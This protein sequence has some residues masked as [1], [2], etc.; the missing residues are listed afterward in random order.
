ME[1]HHRVEKGYVHNQARALTNRDRRR[2]M[3]GD[4][5]A[6]QADVEKVGDRQG[7]FPEGPVASHVVVAP[8]APNSTRLQA[9]N[10]WSQWRGWLHMQQIECPEGVRPEGESFYDC[11][12][13][14]W[15]LLEPYFSE[16]YARELLAL[17][18]Q[19]L[20]PDEGLSRCS[21]SPSG[22]GEAK[23]AQQSRQV[24]IVGVVGDLAPGHAAEGG[25]LECEA[26]VGGR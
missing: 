24:P 20:L 23:L 8:R 15:S 19:L 12:L 13:R 2:L 22:S 25:A 6:A 21:S 3:A 16:R 5:M 26:F 18:R 17:N 1:M 11:A 10:L 14:T 9:E 7:F 4:V